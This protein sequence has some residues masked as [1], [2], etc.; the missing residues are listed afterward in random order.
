M[1]TF[2]DT[3]PEHALEE[4]VSV[5]GPNAYAIE[6]FSW[7]LQLGYKAHEAGSVVIAGYPLEFEWC[8]IV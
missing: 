2:V 8:L 1:K 5:S 4:R 6:N 7:D 3:V